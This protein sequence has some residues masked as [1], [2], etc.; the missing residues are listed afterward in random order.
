MGHKDVAQLLLSY[1][2]NED[3]LA[4]IAPAMPYRFFSTNQ[5]VASS[6]SDDVLTI[7]NDIDLKTDIQGS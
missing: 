2:K 6:S 1:K 5:Y 4:G 7:N 3:K